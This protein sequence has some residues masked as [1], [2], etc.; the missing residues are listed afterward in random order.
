MN[1]PTPLQVLD[2][3]A[4]APVR[5]REIPY[6]YTSFSDREIVLRLLGAEAWGIVEE[7][8]AE[9]RTGRS[10]KMLYEVLGDIWVVRRNPYL[11][12]DLLDNPKRRRQLVEAL[13]HRLGEV[14]RRREADAGAAEAARAA[15][16]A[17]SRSAKVARL[18]GLA[19]EAVARFEREFS[20]AGA[21]R[22]RAL[23]RLAKSTARDN[24]RFDAL[25]RVSHVTDATDWRVEYPFV[26]L[27]PDSEAE[28]AGLVAGCIELG[29]T[30]IPR[31]GGTGYTGGAI[32]LTPL[33]A[34]INTE[35][36]EALGPVEMLRL[37]GLDRE[38][39]TI[40]SEAGVVTKRVTEA[41]ERAGLVF[42][43]D[44]T[45]LEA[46]CVGG[47]VAMNAGGKKA[48]LWGTAL[49][50][51]AW[52]RMVDPDGNWLEVTRVGHN[53]GKI[54][55][56]AVA[57][58]DLKWYAPGQLGADGTMRG[59]P[60]RGQRLDIDGR[61]FRKVG[62]GK[63]VTDKFL[64]G[65]PGVQ[66][67]GCDGLITSARWVLHRMPKH[68][69]TVCLEFFGQPK[70][71][72]P[73]IVEIKTFLDKRPHGAILA[74]LEHLDERYLRAV[75]YTTKSRRGGL[76]KMVLIGDIVGDD[77][78]GVAK[79]TSEVVRMANGR[80]G[81][82]FVAVSP[83]ARKTF[84]LD[85]ARTA[86]IARH[87]N[88]FKINEDV[89]IPLERMG[90]YTDG[91]ERINIELS[92][93]NKLK[94]LDALDA[95]LAGPLALGKS[96]D[97][98]LERLSADELLADRRRQSRE[99]LAA[100]RQ[101]WR[102]LLDDIDEPLAQARGALAGVG[103]GHLAGKADARLA[104]QP[105]AQLFHLLQDRT[106]RV[107]WKLE[108]REP[109][110]QI[111]SGLA[112]SPVLEAVEAAQ[113]RVLRG[114]VWVALHMHAGDG[115]VHTNIPVN[116]DDYEMLKEAEQAVARIM[117][118]A[119][120][121]NGVISGEHGI[122][123][124]KLEFLTDE[125]LRDFRDWKRRIDPQ[126]RFNRGK[127]LDDPDLPGDLRNAYTPSFGLMGVESL[128]M[129]QSDIGSIADSVKDCLRCGK[130]KPVCAT[131][132]P[133]AN[134]LYSPRNKILAT[135]LLVE[136]FLYEEQTRR[137]V[138]I[139]HWD[140]FSDVADHC[141]VCHKCFTPCPVNIDFGDVSMNMRNLLRKMGKKKFNPGGAAAMFF[142][143]A[144]DPDTIK[145]TR[146]AMIGVGYK[147]QRFANDLLKKFA[148]EQVAK[149]PSTVGKAPIREQVIHFVNRKMPGNLP[150]KTARA[151]L[152]IE[153]SRF[154]PII[155]DPK[156]TSIDSEA[157]FY[158]PGCGSER[159][160]S[161]VGLATQAML[162]HAGVQTVLPPGYLCCGY[163]QR[164]SGQYD[165][166]EKIITDNR[167][168]F[169]RVANTLNYL[170]IRTV[171][172]SCGTCYDQLQGYE[173]EKIFPGCRIVDIHEFLMEKGVK[174]EGVTGA[175]Y[176]YHDP[177]HS[178][179]KSYQPL[180]VVNALIDEQLNGRVEKND[181][182]CGESGT[183]AVTRPDIST[184][185]R[186]RKAEEMRKGAAAL[187]D[188]PVAAAGEAGAFEGPVKVL[189]S[190]PSCLQGLSRY[191]DETG[192]DADY[193]VVE[194]AR[195]RH[196]ENWMADYVAA[197][198]A[199]GIERV[200]V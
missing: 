100:T 38:V 11:Q 79:A 12:D 185:V 191:S 192:V 139:R 196:G 156:A 16:A 176:M 152:D 113:Q 143:N 118:L 90:E 57:S 50:N 183:L 17:G 87:T 85:R 48:V 132:V 92:I 126:G 136:A 124:T 25:S 22:Q 106:I 97:V 170:D 76:P 150:K 88:A 93:R 193:I 96:D 20:E 104:E 162:W 60:I 174:L 112:F 184:Q 67:E 131:H 200:L 175:R 35:K 2:P 36:L 133:R 105:Q 168:L 15:D 94:V 80:A 74:G 4:D 138:S 141:T 153:D 134:L 140:E 43:V 107:S 159:L 99:L 125:E 70:D 52:W 101:R 71:A 180:K 111:F 154:V 31:G 8:R 83:D 161:Q 129:Q 151:L 28:I 63:D 54:H 199:G 41:A 179:I 164:G 56:A 27:T 7:L 34:V 128:I 91:I 108:V 119:R 81:E 19:R 98:D 165:K 127:L 62:L 197:A 3:K 142:L 86:A 75:G 195:N 145:A 167:V 157:V 65:L 116:S 148:R 39:P 24:I 64:S 58:F 171:V 49:D 66:K 46:S 42:A 18:L 181:R 14:D 95:L 30:I 186:F 169:H 45:S 1:A 115:N 163:P 55:D 44:P 5:L 109:L 182:C 69:R 82:G 77:D 147:A 10:A 123:I 114:R 177:C 194:L 166:A 51:L 68:V 198:N 73:S 120:S 13:H 32:P 155:R 103:L 72:V 130:C 188:I 144:T 117:K 110:R 149:P 61:R 122:G 135:S 137:G 189:T 89:V 47:N 121:L 53:L 6:N 9:R 29:L 102:W 40:L 146:A 172:V 21:L 59:E 23:R 37:P 158:F 160:F 173:F 190:C 26:V 178:P 33:S 84:W 78:E 187:R